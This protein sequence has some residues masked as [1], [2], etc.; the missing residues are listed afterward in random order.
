MGGKMGKV[1]GLGV[2]FRAENPKSLREWYLEN[3][4]I[5]FHPDYL[6]TVFDP[7]EQAAI[8]NA[9]QVFSLMPSDTQYFEPSK[10]DFMLNLCVDDIGFFLDKFKA[11]NIE[12]LWQDLQSEHGKFAHIL[13]I[14]G[15]KIE[16]WQPSE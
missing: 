14:E 2:F 7:K 5:D 9:N 11:N 6:F 10:K 12:V 16:L 1:V 13:D 15:N 3:L 8:N 4:G